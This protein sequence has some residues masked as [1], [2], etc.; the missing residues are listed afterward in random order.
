MQLCLQVRGAAVGRWQCNYWND[1]C[2]AKTSWVS[3]TVFQVASSIVGG[4]ICPAFAMKLFS[5]EVPSCM[6]QDVQ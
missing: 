5:A 3:V 6:Q 2:H 4:L 1:P